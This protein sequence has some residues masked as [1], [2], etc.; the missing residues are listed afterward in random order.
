MTRKPTRRTV[1]RAINDLENGDDRLGSGPTEWKA[2]V[3]IHPGEN[4]PLPDD[5]REHVQQRAHTFESVEDA[6]DALDS[7]G[8]TGVVGW[9]AE[10]ALEDEREQ[11]EQAADADHAAP[12]VAAEDAD[13]L[14]LPDAN[15]T[16]GT[17]PDVLA[18][19]REQGA[20]DGDTEPEE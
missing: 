2:Y 11:V 7:G 14:D 1:E 4:L 18:D 9:D 16:V 5:A 10:T 12:V 8:P 17:D 6:A 20:F 3:G 13:A 15:H 19:D